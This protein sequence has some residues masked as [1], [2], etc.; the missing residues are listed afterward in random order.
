M[1]VDFG[2]DQQPKRALPLGPEARNIPRCPVSWHFHMIQPEVVACEVFVGEVIPL[3]QAHPRG[4][5]KL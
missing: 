4:H 2:L 1:L 3:S 5:G